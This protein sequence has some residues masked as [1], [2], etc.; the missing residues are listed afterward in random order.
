MTPLLLPA[1]QHQL[2]QGHGAAHRC[3][4]PVA[5]FDRQNHLERQLD[6]M[7]DLKSKPGRWLLYG[8][9]LALKWIYWVWNWNLDTTT[10]C[11]NQFT[12]D[13]FKKP[14]CCYIWIRMQGLR[15]CCC[16][17]KALQRLQVGLTFQ[18]IQTF[19]WPL[20]HEILSVMTVMTFSI[21][22]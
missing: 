2:V 15:I 4:Q 20:R 5:L 3:R 1:V 10:L 8:I 6:M 7:R 11:L 22:I 14:N 21:N 9:L 16:I 12:Y 19:L 13:Q 17:Y 18:I